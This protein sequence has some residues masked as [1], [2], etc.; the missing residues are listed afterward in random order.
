MAPEGRLNREAGTGTQ[1]S[2]TGEV[3]R[4]GGATAARTMGWENHPHQGDRDAPGNRGPGCPF[5]GG[6]GTLLITLQWRPAVQ[7][8]IQCNPV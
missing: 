8:G 1:Y 2:S 5:R 6:L 4:S 7:T 3:R